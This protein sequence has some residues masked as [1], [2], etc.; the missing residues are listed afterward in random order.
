VALSAARLGVRVRDQLCE[1]V[2]LG[3]LEYRLD[4]LELGNAPGAV[5]HLGERSFA[6]L[7]V[8]VDPGPADQAC[9]TVEAAHSGAAGDLVDAPALGK[10]AAPRP[11]DDREGADV[12]LTGETGTLEGLGVE[13]QDAACRL[14]SEPVPR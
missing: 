11:R 10:D 12:G 3:V 8:V 13:M 9:R 2:D 7:F 4:S 1:P 14:S 6:V 5:A